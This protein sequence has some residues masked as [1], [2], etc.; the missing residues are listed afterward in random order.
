MRISYFLP[1]LICNTLQD[2]TSSTIR[3]SPELPILHW[4]MIKNYV[5]TCWENEIIVIIADSN[6]NINSL[7]ELL[8]GRQYLFYEKDKI[9]TNNPFL[10]QNLHSQNYL[11]FWVFTDDIQNMVTAL[12]PIGIVQSFSHV[13]FF[14]EIPKEPA[15]IFEWIMKKENPNNV[16]LFN[17][18]SSRVSVFGICLYCDHGKNVVKALKVWSR[19][20]M[21]K[22]YQCFGNSFKGNFFGGELKVSNIVKLP[23]FFKSGPDEGSAVYD[24]FEYQ[25]LKVSTRSDLKMGLY[26]VFPPYFDK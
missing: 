20:N 12:R 3:V 6:H 23:Y 4:D 2:T 14:T 10:D 9:G 26:L 7:H 15:K 5:E 1:I 21:L 8:K 19:K 17:A 13:Y 22:R 18:E 24:G 11:Q 16:F 25:L